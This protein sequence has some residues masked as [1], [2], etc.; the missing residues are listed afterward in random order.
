M[1][2]TVEIYDGLWPRSSLW[3]NYTTKRRYKLGEK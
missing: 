2:L 3:I 1:N